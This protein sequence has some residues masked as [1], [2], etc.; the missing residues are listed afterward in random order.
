MARRVAVDYLKKRG[1]HEVFVRLAY[2]IGVAEP[3]EATVIVDGQPE[4]IKGYDLTPN[5]IIKYLNLRRPIYEATARYG[6]FGEG[7]DWD[8]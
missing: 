2:A 5:G 3:L 7:F 8:K 4:V 1:A 6:H